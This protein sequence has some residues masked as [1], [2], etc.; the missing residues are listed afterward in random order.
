MAIMPARIH[1]TRL[2]SLAWYVTALLLVLWFC[3][4][5]WK[6]FLDAYFPYSG[7]VVE[8]GIDQNFLLLGGR[9]RYIVIQ[10]EAGHSTKKYVGY[11]GYAFAHIGTFVVKK[12][13]F[14]EYPFP[15]DEK[16]PSEL[17]R[18]GEKRTGKP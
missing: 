3:P 4:W 7:V 12:K 8:K 11:Y 6:G 5:R 9:G 14:G 15:P 10:D 1:S 16:H 2:R 17:L 13:G 18:E